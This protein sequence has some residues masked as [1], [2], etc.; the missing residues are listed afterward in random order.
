ME[1][2]LVNLVES[3]GTRPQT[4]PSAWGCNWAALLLG[5]LTFQ[6]EGVSNLIQLNMVMNPAELGPE[7]DCAGEAQQQL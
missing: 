3:L 1:F 5:D 7:N 2:S 4:K 6:I